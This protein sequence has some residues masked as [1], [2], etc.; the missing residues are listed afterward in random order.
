MKFCFEVV[1]IGRALL[2]LG[3][4]TQWGAGAQAIMSLQ[5]QDIDFD[6]MAV[7][8]DPPYGIEIERDYFD[9]ACERIAKVQC[10]RLPDHLKTSQIIQDYPPNID[11]VAAVYPMAKTMHGV[12]FSYGEAIY[13]P[14]GQ[15][16]PPE[17][18]A[19]EMVHCVRQLKHPEG[20]QGW[21]QQYLTN[22]EFCYNEELLAHKAEYASI[23]ER[24]P[25]RQTRR[26]ALRHVAKKLSSALY[27]KVVT[28]E[29]AKKA[30]QS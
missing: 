26:Q 17:I 6:D 9:A 4:N 15:D 5:H 23:C 21:W 3:D 18:L 14:S 29:K 30:L 2:L 27:G 16:L 8:S 25:S 7:V 13:N 24:H 22:A 19:H 1:R 12:I 28:F 11:E 20:V 10:E